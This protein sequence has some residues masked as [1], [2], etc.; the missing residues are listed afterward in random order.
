M[1]SLPTDAADEEIAR[2]RAALHDIATRPKVE[3]NP[4][5]VDQAAWTMA[6]IAEV[7]LAEPGRVQP[8][9]MSQVL[10]WA[11]DPDWT[12]RPSDPPGCVE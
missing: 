9:H 7:A 5:G 1:S 10:S 2:L 11:R 8:L 3:L 4:D 12:H 6:L